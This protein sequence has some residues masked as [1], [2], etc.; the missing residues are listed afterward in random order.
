M[1]GVGTPEV[2]V[3]ID[4]RILVNFLL[5]S[6]KIWYAIDVLSKKKPSFEHQVRRHLVVIC[7]RIFL[8]GCGA[9]QISAFLNCSDMRCPSPLPSSFLDV[10]A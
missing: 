5:S 6:I 9:F 10:A 8:R 2:D 7:E 4:Q 3:R 1:V